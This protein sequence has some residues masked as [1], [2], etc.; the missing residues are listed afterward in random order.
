M[1]LDHFWS[2]ASVKMAKK[3]AKKTQ[4]K[5]NV[6]ASNTDRT[7]DGNAETTETEVL[8]LAMTK[9]LGTLTANISRVMEVRF[10][11]FLQKI[12]NILKELQDT[13][14]RFGEAEHHISTVSRT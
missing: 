11:S 2:K 14:K 7:Q 9:A 13:A 1:S 10:D 3:S 5:R 4:E 8:S 6:M 12:G